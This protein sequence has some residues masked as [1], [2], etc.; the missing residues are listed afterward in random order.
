MKRQRS[1]SD[2]IRT[3]RFIIVLLLL[4]S[5][6]LAFAFTAKT[7]MTKYVLADE[8]A[9][10]VTSGWWLNSVTISGTAKQNETL[11]LDTLDPSDALAS[12]SVNYQWE[13]CDTENG[14]YFTIIGATENE[15]TL[16]VNEVGKYVRLTVMGRSATVFQDFSVSSETKGPVEQ[17][18]Q[19]ALIWI[20]PVGGSVN[21]PIVA[22]ITLE[23]IVDPTLVRDPNNWNPYSFWYSDS[24]N[25]SYTQA[26]NYNG[27]YLNPS[28]IGKYIRARFAA[29]SGYVESTPVIV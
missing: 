6:A 24:L 26:T 27:I 10:N 19:A 16:T 22:G 15:Y 2:I 14:E 4:F 18:G 20:R 28:Y 3:M 5:L 1:G 11:R 29:S 7:T 21:D 23:A 12:D 8:L 13:Y 25:G 17:A 9:L